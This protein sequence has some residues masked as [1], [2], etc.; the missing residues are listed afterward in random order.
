MKVS[1]CE[2]EKVCEDVKMRRCDRR[3]KDEIQT[4]T[5]EEPCTQTPTE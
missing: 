2:G 5:M 4:P 3:C 1:K